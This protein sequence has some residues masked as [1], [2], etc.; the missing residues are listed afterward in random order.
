MSALL[1]LPCLVKIVLLSPVLLGPLL[2]IL[3]PASLLVVSGQDHN[4]TRMAS[5][6]GN[7]DAPRSE[8]ENASAAEP[9]QSIW[10]SIWENN[11]GALLILSSVVCGAS[12]DAIAR[13]LQQGGAGFHTLQVCPLLIPGSS[14]SSG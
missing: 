2:D 3:L 7:E 1:V 4:S 5:N 14:D 10:C 9:D 6:N 8:D 12:M 13:F 11:K